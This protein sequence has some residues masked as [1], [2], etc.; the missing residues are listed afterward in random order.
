MN[1]LRLC[2]WGRAEGDPSIRLNMHTHDFCQLQ[3]SLSGECDFIT[4]SGRIRLRKN[5]IL[6]VAPNVPHRLEYRRKYLS[7]AYKF[8]C[9][10]MSDFAPFVHLP[11]NPLT[12]GIIEAADVILYTTFPLRFLD[13]PEGTVI[14][15]GSRYQVL[16]EHFLS[17]VID[18]LFRERTAGSAAGITAK[19]YEAVKLSPANVFSVKEAAGSCHYTRSHFSAL[20]RQQTGQSAREFLNGIKL[21]IAKNYLL[22]SEK[23]IAEIAQ[24]L[25]FSSQFHFSTFFKR[26]EGISPL[27]F[28][29]RKTGSSR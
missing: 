12:A 25:G 15:P 3:F 18:C 22:Y 8:Y 27:K 26:H 28:R 10:E 5:D 1:G 23:S 24:L 20:V 14:L 21:K 4:E 11:G 9:D 6:L 2:F 7:Q 16:M 17:G 19:I 29:R 13:V